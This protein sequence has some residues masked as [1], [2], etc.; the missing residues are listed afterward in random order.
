ML[1]FRQDDRSAETYAPLLRPY[2]WL[3]YPP[4]RRM[5]RTQSWGLSADYRDRRASVGGEP[6]RA[7]AKGGHDPAPDVVRQSGI[8]GD[9]SSL[10]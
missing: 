4:V 3:P 7:L 2:R 5:P 9:L 6:E 8:V 10:Q 1:A